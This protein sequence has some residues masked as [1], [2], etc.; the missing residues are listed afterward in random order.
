VEHRLI[1]ILKQA[2]LV[3]DKDIE[4]VLG[5]QMGSKRPLQDVLVDMGIV[6]EDKMYEVLSEW[7]KI[8]VVDLSQEEIDPKALDLVP[9]EITQKYGVFPLRVEGDILVVAMSNPT[10][11]TAIQDL[12]A[13]TKHRIKPVLAQKSAIADAVEKNYQMDSALYDILKNIDVDDSDVEFLES[14]VEDEDVEDL[15]AQ[16]RLAPIIRLTN[17]IIADACRRSAS[18]IHIEPDE[19]KLYVRFR[20]DGQLR[21]IMELPKKLHPPLV[22]RIKIMAKMDI[23]ERR[24]PQD[25]HAMVVM[26]GK[27][28]DLRVSTLPTVFGEK[29]VIR[30]LDKDAANVQLDGVGMSEEELKAFRNAINQPQG[31]VLLTGPTGSGKTT[32]LYAALN[33]IKSERKNIVTVEDPVEYQIEGI[34]QVQVNEKAGLTF[35]AGLRSIL[36]QDPDVILLGEIRDA[37]TARIAFQASITGHLVL[38]T[39][40]TNDAVSAITRLVD[41]GIEHFIIAS[42]LLCIVAQRLVRCIC[43]NCRDEYTPPKEILEKISNVLPP[44]EHKFYIGRGCEKCDFTGYKGR[45]GIFEMLVV[46]DEIRQLISDKAAEYIILEKA[47]NKGMKLLSEAGIEKALQG[48]TTLEEVMSV[49]SVEKDIISRCPECGAPIGKDY[50]RCPK[51]GAEVS[52]KCHNCGRTLDV[53][54]SICPYCGTERR[55]LLSEQVLA[56][57]R[58]DGRKRVLIV[59]DSEAI[60]A[61]V[62]AALKDGDYEF[63]EAADGEEALRL[64]FQAKPDI[65]ILDIMMP[66]VDGFQVCRKMRANLETATIP[67]VMLTAKVDSE[68]RLEGLDAGADDYITKP[69]DRA[70]LA[71]RVKMLLEDKSDLPI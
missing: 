20:I 64:I 69:F 62:K 13:L 66:K 15:K 41:I 40:H 6:P 24:K 39:L 27:E 45:T 31:M 3:D 4:E 5:K 17:L 33:E 22:S 49:A 57:G 46:D 42:S 60:R 19:R 37:E 44:G 10:D 14:K 56:G 48:I 1:T 63:L 54:W 9:Y 11:L 30:I 36:R 16:S 47:R 51:C 55:K 67:V 7:L 38:S 52:D 35:A 26:A 25:G 28:L 43:P 32:T 18:D 8:P 70:Q 53:G 65:V 58:S 71:K 21:L 61:M 23:A 68:S 2:G 59:D 29:V 50:L 34:N 12:E